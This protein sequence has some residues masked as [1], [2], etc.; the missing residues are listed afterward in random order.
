LHEQLQALQSQKC[1][2]RWEIVVADNGSTD[3]TAAA[4]RRY[5][6]A[7]P[8]L[9][10]VDA[11]SV[12]GPAATR[13]L[14]VGASRGDVLA[15]CDAD[16]VVHPGWVESWLRALEDAD[17]AAGLNDTWSLN[18]PQPLRPFAPRPPPQAR[19]FGFLDAAGSGNMAVRRDAFEVVGGFD[20]E[21]FVGEDTDICWRIQLAGYKFA[22]GSGV[23]SRRERSGTIALLK[24]SIQYGRCGPI[25]Y[26][27]Y[28]HRG[29]RA[30]PRAALRAWLYVIVN[31]PRLIDPQFRQT[32]ARVAG[33]RIGRLVG[34]C[35]YFVFFP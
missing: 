2:S 1:S 14:G 19:Q 24:R 20:E 34:S 11:S 23:I 6:A 3:G 31:L 18:S 33:W 32:W 7:D 22:I 27:R 10:L 13:N 16:D 35:R 28:R 15:F 8:R 4:V 26:R 30:D 12:T 9:H 21:L 17:V 25:L 29:M 5:A